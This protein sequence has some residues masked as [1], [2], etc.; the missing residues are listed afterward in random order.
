MRCRGLLEPHG[1]VKARRSILRESPARRRA[2]HMDQQ[3]NLQ[4]FTLTHTSTGALEFPH[5][6]HMRAFGLWEEAAAS[7]PLQRCAAINQSIFGVNTSQ[8][9]KSNCALVWYWFNYK[10][11]YNMRFKTTKVGVLA[12][13]LVPLNSFEFFLRQK[14]LTRSKCSVYGFIF[15]F[16]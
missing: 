3:T 14:H 2:T 1:R 4:R 7:R 10:S 15:F 6:P 8:C 13:R 16:F 11:L 12:T 9:L 5:Q